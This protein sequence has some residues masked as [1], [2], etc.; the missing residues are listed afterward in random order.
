L[1]SSATA[2]VRIT[3][4]HGGNMGVYW[5]RYL[6]LRE[7]NELVVIDGTCSSAC[8]LILGMIPADRVCI[9]PNAVFG[10]HA[11]WNSGFLGLPV[12]NEPATR[13]LM[14]VYPARIRNWIIRH[15]GLRQKMLY[16]SGRSL[17]G[18]Y[19]QCH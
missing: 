19:R 6:A 10:F 8:T 17:V 9:T 5:S 1:A 3:D 16:L 7:S 12:T 11:A 2:V 15:G 13:T 4:D 14:M 18:F